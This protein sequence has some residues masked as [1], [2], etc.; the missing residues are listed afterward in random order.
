MRTDHSVWGCHAHRLVSITAI[1]R[2]DHSVSG[3]SCTQAVHS[4]GRLHLGKLCTLAVRPRSCPAPRPFG[5]RA[6]LDT[7]GSVTGRRSHRPFCLRAVVHTVCLASGL[8]RTQ[9][10]RSWS[11]NAHRSFGL[12]PVMHTGRLVSE[13]P[14]TQAAIRSWGCHAHRLLSIKAVM[15]TDHWASSLSCAQT[16][17]SQERC[18]HSPF[19]LGAVMHAFFLGAACTQ[20]VQLRVVVLSRMVSGWQARLAAPMHRSSSSRGLL[21]KQPPARFEHARRYVSYP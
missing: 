9:A 11:C 15:R 6:V 2:T 5:L 1:M 14:C 3:L 7:S 17:C 19:G 13:L 4:Q 21:P 16:I 12:T 18:A 10:S 20:E 8:S